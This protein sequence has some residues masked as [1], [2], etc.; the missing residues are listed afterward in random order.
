MT[1]LTESA[2]EDFANR[3]FERLGCVCIHTRMA[4]VCSQ[5]NMHSAEVAD[6]G[7]TR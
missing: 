2:I 7:I 5:L 6:G 4:T 3:L 1:K